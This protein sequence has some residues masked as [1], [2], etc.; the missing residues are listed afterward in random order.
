VS[1]QTCSKSL[2]ESGLRLEARKLP[3]RFRVPAK[4]FHKG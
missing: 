4:E 2:P 3:K 1:N